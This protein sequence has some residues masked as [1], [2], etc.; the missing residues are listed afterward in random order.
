M[1]WRVARVLSA[2]IITHPPRNQTVNVGDN[3][4]L[5]CRFHSDIEAYVHWIKLSDDVIT[6]RSSGQSQLTTDLN[7][8]ITIQVCYYQDSDLTKVRVFMPSLSCLRC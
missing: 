7:S 3:V 2:P 6:A 1:T 5:H 8:F 4:T